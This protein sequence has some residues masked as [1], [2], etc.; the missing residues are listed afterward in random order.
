MNKGV[1]HLYIKLR[2][3]LWIYLALDL[4]S[5]S[6]WKNDDWVVTLLQTEFPDEITNP[7]LVFQTIQ[8]CTI[9]DIYRHFLSLKK[10]TIFWNIFK[11]AAGMKFLLLCTWLQCLWKCIHVCAN[12]TVQQFHFRGLRKWLAAALLLSIEKQPPIADKREI[13]IAEINT[14]FSLAI[15]S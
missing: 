11:C 4:F 1:L 14:T 9:H 12:T 15:L 3:N 6:P 8:G 7:T 13:N 2:T 5:H 10:I